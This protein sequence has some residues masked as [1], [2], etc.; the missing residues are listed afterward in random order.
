MA[1]LTKADERRFHLARQGDWDQFTEYYF[2]LPYSGTWYTPEDREEQYSVLWHAWRSSGKP[3]E[4]LS[5]LVDGHKMNYSITFGDYGD[6]PAFLRRHGFLFLPWFR[7]VLDAR[8]DVDVIEGGT[9]TGKTGNV[10]VMALSLCALFPGFD[11][12]NT[13]PTG[14]QAND[15][16]REIAK[17]VTGTKFEQFIV[18]SR[19]GRLYSVQQGQYIVTVD[20]GLGTYSTFK[21]VTVGKKQ[22]NYTLGDE[23]DGVSIDEASLLEGIGETVPRYVTRIRG[24]RRNGLPRRTFPKSV[25]RPP[26]IIFMTNPH[27]NPSFVRLKNTAQEEMIAPTSE[28]TYHCYSPSQR[29]NVYVTQ[30]QRRLME[31]LMSKRQMARWLEGKN[32]T[33]DATG[34]ISQSLINACYDEAMDKEVEQA[35]AIGCLYEE[36]DGMGLTGYAIPPRPGGIYAV[37]GDPGTSSLGDIND[38]NVPVVGV[39]ETGAFPDGP[40]NIVAF[41]V[42]DGQGRFD[43]WV[44]QV[45]EWF[46]EYQAV[47]GAYDATS[48]QSILSEYPLKQFPTLYPLTMSGNNK[49]IAKTF[50]VL[51]AGK[52]LF[53]WPY[54]DRLW[55]EAACYRES[56]PGVHKLPDDMLSALFSLCLYVRITKHALLPDEL[57]WDEHKAKSLHDQLREQETKKVS[58]HSRYGRK[59]GRYTRRR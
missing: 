37:F 33:F 15:M 49:A 44:Q 1:K 12:I 35:A 18:R 42:F 58:K 54:L 7:N 6:D 32:V 53:R 17:W 52:E 14:R 40:L 34:I 25:I 51:L 21:T 19:S 43:T 16:L 41:R 26:G 36:Q 39:A 50:F 46:T 8:A 2:R 27:L 11:W 29:E 22:G 10:G 9:G 38:N 31:S 5:L 47:G 48:A 28:T 45:I 13:A 59:S 24:T 3:E 23:C 20:C 4:K 30:R 57:K 55:H 56:G